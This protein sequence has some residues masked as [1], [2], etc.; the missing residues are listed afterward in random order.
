MADFPEENLNEDVDSLRVAWMNELNSPE[1]LSFQTDLISDMV[2]QVQNQQSYVDEIAADTAAMTEERSFANKLYQ[3]EIDRIKYMLASY[4]RIRLMKIEQHTIHILNE[5]QDK[6]S[7]GEVEYAQQ[8]HALYV[9]HCN[10]LILS[11]FPEDQ[12]KLD[13]DH[14]VDA[15]DL[16]AFVFCQSTEDI[17][18]VQ[19]DD[20]GAEH[21]NARKDDR[22]VLRYCVIRSLVEQGKMKL[23]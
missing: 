19:I 7:Q 3:M 20:R 17:G 9:S 14:M 16:D 10:D 22:H 18:N 11:K 15:P 5:S 21:V 8:Y 13:E 2:E 6:L 4:L 12:Q 1:L 23:L